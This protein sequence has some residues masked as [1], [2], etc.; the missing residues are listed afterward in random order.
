MKRDAV[1]ATMW[2]G[3]EVIGVTPVG[4]QPPTESELDAMADALTAAPE[5]EGVKP[6]VRIVEHF[7]FL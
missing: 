6:V 2:D 5:Q 7:S 1:V 3:A 4:S